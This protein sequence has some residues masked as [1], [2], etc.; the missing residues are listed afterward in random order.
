M[1]VIPETEPQLT[2]EQVEELLAH[3][4]RLPELFTVAKALLKPHLFRLNSEPQL[5]AVWETAL[6]L[7]AAHGEKALTQN[8]LATECQ[9]FLQANDCLY[10]F[11]TAD[12]I[13]RSDPQNPGLLQRIFSASPS[14]FDSG[15]GRELLRKFLFER[16]ISDQ[17]RELAFSSGQENIVN[18]CEILKD[19]AAKEA[20]FKRLDQVTGG[21]WHDDWTEFEA[22][23]ASHQGGELIGLKTGM[24]ELDNRTLGLRG[25]MVLGAGPGV[26]KTTYAQ[27]LGL[28]VCR[29]NDDAVFLMLSLEMDK[30]ALYTRMLCNVAG[31]SWKTLKLGSP[32]CRGKQGP[33][34]TPEDQARLDKARQ[35]LRESGL[36]KRIRIVGREQLGADLTPDDVASILN[37]FKKSTGAKR[38][39]VVIDYLQL[40]PT[41]Q[42]ILRHGDLDADRYRVQFVQDL[43]AKTKTTENPVGDA[44]LVISETRKPSGRKTWG[45]GLADLMGSARLPYAVDAALLYNTIDNESFL[46][47]YYWPPLTNPTC[48]S[49]QDAGIAPVTLSLAKGRDGMI[50]GD[51]ALAY[52]FE[53]SRFEEVEKKPSRPAGNS[54]PGVSRPVKNKIHFNPLELIDVAN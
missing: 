40:I 50:R 38:A 54:K 53:E 12:E 35:E 24:R 26:G 44:V 30:Q 15:Y 3:L 31:V 36:T 5:R 46:S 48:Q 2:C 33:R 11:S 47:E 22:F 42:E 20:T 34:Y 27:Q 16:E 51:W 52:R 17:L 49:L 19:L 39:L 41:P 13:C 6:N 37:E 10:A 25:L 14:E 18:A 45:S 23:L 8:R 1:T 4:L 21:C 29:N 7:T 28:E 9:V 43:L 32:S